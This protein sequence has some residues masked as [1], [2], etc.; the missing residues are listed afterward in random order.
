MLNVLE[1]SVEEGVDDTTAN[2]VSSIYSY[3][4]YVPSSLEYMLRKQNQLYVSVNGVYVQTSSANTMKI[5]SHDHI[6]AFL[7]L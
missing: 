4:F 5:N 6:P 7:C 3:I 2:E 1:S